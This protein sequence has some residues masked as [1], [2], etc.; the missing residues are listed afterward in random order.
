MPEAKHM[1]SSTMYAS[2]GDFRRIFHEETDS[3]YRLS[4]LLTADREKAEQ[5]FVSGLEDSVNG[6]PVFK[7]WARSWA[8]RAIIHNAV[9]VINPRPTDEHAPP[10]LNSDG[11]TP[12]GE[13]A[14]IAAVLELGPFERFVYV[15][16]VLEHYSDQDCLVLL[17]CALRDVIAARIRALQQIDMQSSFTLSGR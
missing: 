1:T 9:R 7:E 8:R 3:L 16:S 14:E 15:M 11:K 4:F 5:C 10:S 2:S 17:G 12:A 6:S 13:E